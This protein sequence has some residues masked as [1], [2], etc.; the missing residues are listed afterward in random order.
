M[1]T[2][3]V[4]RSPYQRSPQRGGWGTTPA[5]IS[6][7]LVGSG[8]VE[9]SQLGYATAKSAL[10][11]ACVDAFETRAGGLPVYFE[12]PL[13]R[14]TC[15]SCDCPLFLVAQIYAPTDRDRSL[16]IFGC[17]SVLCNGFGA[18]SP[19]MRT[20]G[21]LWTVQ[22]TQASAS[23]KPD[24]ATAVGA[25]V[26]HPPG[27]PL[28]ETDPWGAVGAWGEA[29]PLATPALPLATPGAMES[30][31]TAQQTPSVMPPASPLD[32]IHFPAFAI[33]T[34]DDVEDEGEGD[35]GSDGD[36][37]SSAGGAKA[38][39]DSQRWRS[40]EEWRA[41]A[42]Q[43]AEDAVGGGSRG[44]RG[45][46][47]GHELGLAPEGEG[48][49]DD[50]VGEDEGSG[51]EEVAGLATGMSETLA[52]TEAEGSRPR[53]R[54][55]AASAAPGGWSA[56]GEG[57]PARSSPAAPAARRDARPQRG[58]A[59]AGAG[60]GSA[61]AGDA[62]EALPAET[63]F[64]LRWQ[65]W[66]KH[67]GHPCVRYAYGLAPRWPVPPT[68]VL[69]TGAVPPCACGRARVFELQIL[70][71]ILSLLSVDEYTSREPGARD[72]SKSPASKGEVTTVAAGGATAGG[73]APPEKGG[74]VIGHAG[75]GSGRRVG[76]GPD[77][78]G[79]RLVIGGGMD[80]SSV[81]VYSCPESCA[82]SSVEVAIVIPNL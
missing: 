40:Y 53:R 25:T 76:G 70:P 36:S 3:S 66:L 74:P 22:R 79:P 72:V 80:F 16:L 39:D 59:A 81:L 37:T 35:G 1:N 73:R 19:A 2:P 29:E 50:G 32:R 62:Y 49:S 46:S 75:G 55:W 47:G 44:G 48:D 67:S 58:A 51:A 9:M 54:G 18:D 31:A 77:S 6:I 65:S 5:S 64:M 21:A 23:Y 7:L 82:M 28:V 41:A 68:D 30:A 71:A 61:E 14:P 10:G 52:L 4:C 20:P 13:E 17:N 12:R 69:V 24:S 56:P 34:F 26:E 43:D 27:Q 60:R 33:A 45:G 38:E 11:R 78:A 63:R 42:G 15:R 8:G 57:G